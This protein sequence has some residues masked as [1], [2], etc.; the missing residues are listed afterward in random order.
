MYIVNNRVSL[1]PTL[2]KWWLNGVVSDNQAFNWKH[3]LKW[4]NLWETSS[5]EKSALMLSS[6]KVSQLSTSF[7][8]F[9]VFFSHFYRVVVHAFQLTGLA[10]V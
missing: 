4:E 5:N 6:T 10:P 7:S 9:L 1:Y 2:P 3:V 8:Q